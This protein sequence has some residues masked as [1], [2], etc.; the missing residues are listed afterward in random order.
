MNK[1]WREDSRSCLNPDPLRSFLVQKKNHPQLCLSCAYPFLSPPVPPFSST[2]RLT[3]TYSLL[4]FISSFRSFRS[5]TKVRPGG[6]PRELTKK[7]LCTLPGSAEWLT[8]SC[9]WSR[10]WSSRQSGGNPSLEKKNNTRSTNVSRLNL[11]IWKLHNCE[12]LCAPLYDHQLIFVLIRISS[13]GAQGFYPSACPTSN[14][15]PEPF[16]TR[17]DG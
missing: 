13:Y 15:E 4:S 10:S 5:F 17:S 16:T 1:K 11:I 12:I 6:G 8:L 3:E 9:L 7:V 14:L 2:P